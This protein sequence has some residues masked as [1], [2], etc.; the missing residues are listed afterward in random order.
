MAWVYFKCGEFDLA[1]VAIDQ[2]IKAGGRLDNPDTATYAAHLLYQQGKEWDAKQ[3]LEN[4][5]KNDRPFS[6]RPEAKKLYEKVKD[7]K[8][9]KPLRLP[10]RP[11][12]KVYVGW[13]RAQRRPTIFRHLWWVFAGLDATLHRFN[14]ALSYNGLYHDQPAPD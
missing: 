12:P 8:K 4:L 13:R 1:Q 14:H 3:L 10:T 7:A 11:E 5:L 6:M 9:R 2:A